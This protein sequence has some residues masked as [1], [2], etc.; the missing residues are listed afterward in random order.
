MSLVG[1]GFPPAS[2]TL[3]S[4]IRQIE[5]GNAL[6]VQMQALWTASPAVWIETATSGIFCRFGRTAKAARVGPY[7]RIVYCLK[8]SVKSYLNCRFDIYCF[9]HITYLSQT[10]LQL[11]KTPAKLRYGCKRWLT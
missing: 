3:S 2:A 10:D 6:I 9:Q 4:H 1:T 8:T 7:F 5:Y 11:C